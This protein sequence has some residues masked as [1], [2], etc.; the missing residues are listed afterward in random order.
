MGTGPKPPLH[1]AADTR[2]R[3]AIA[4][5]A[6]GRLCGFAVETGA[7]LFTVDAHGGPVLDVAVDETATLLASAGQDGVVRVGCC[8]TGRSVAEWAWC[9]PVLRCAITSQ[10]RGSEGYR[11][12]AGEHARVMI[13]AGDD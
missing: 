10:L 13:V 5:G 1:L 9:R 12:H 7:P 11:M 8:R 4:G 3:Y 2:G 6:D